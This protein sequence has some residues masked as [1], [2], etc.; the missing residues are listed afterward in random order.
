MRTKQQNPFFRKLRDLLTLSVDLVSVLKDLFMNDHADFE[1]V[2]R[3]HSRS[4][5][6]AKPSTPCYVRGWIILIKP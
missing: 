4:W 6:P 1:K 3:R 2:L 5:K